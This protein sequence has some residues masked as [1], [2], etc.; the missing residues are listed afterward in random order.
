MYSRVVLGF[1][2]ICIYIDTGEGSYTADRVRLRTGFTDNLQLS[3]VGLWRFA[4]I[5]DEG[6]GEDAL[7]RE[8]SALS[9]ISQG[10]ILQRGRDAAVWTAEEATS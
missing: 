1:M 6:R 7:P 4:T 2:Y 9:R 10:P 8:L 5:V 3:I